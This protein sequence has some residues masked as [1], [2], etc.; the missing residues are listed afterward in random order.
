MKYT[1]YFSQ[2]LKGNGNPHLNQDMFALHMNMVH[3]LGCVA[4][5]I[6]LAG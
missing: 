2:I 1:S 3:L 5:L 6:Y 4:E